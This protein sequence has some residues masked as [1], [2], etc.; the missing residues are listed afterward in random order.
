MSLQV[1]AARLRLLL[2]G[3]LVLALLAAGITVFLTR[4][5]DG[6]AEREYAVPD[7]L[8]GLDVPRELYEPLFPPGRDL[9][10]EQSYE[11][12]T[13]LATLDQ[14]RITVDGELVIWSDTSGLDGFQAFIDGRSAALVRETGELGYEVPEGTPV[15]GE[16]EAM[17]WPGFAI[18]G[19][20]CEPGQIIHSFTVG[21]GASH[22]AD[23]AESVETFAALIQPFMAAAVDA[24]VC[25][26]GDNPASGY[27]PD[28]GT[29]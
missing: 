5:S 18:A 3:A 15:S 9:R 24:S 1:S 16:F 14:C 12:S 25:S 11:G 22:L 4:G 19:T 17:A 8:C 23:D 28:R 29:G 10:I 7:T 2:G 13:G 21:L 20:S 26:P 27:A 6:P